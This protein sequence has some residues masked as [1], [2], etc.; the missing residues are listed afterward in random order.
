MDDENFKLAFVYSPKA[1]VKQSKIEIGKSFLL[2]R[3]SFFILIYLSNY[4]IW[5]TENRF[6][7]AANDILTHRRLL[8]PQY[9]KFSD[10]RILL[11]KSVKLFT[12]RP[13]IMARFPNLL[14]NNDE[15][16]K[17]RKDKLNK[18]LGIVT[19]TI[20]Y[21]NGLFTEEVFTMVLDF[22]YTGYLNFPLLSLEHILLVYE[23][24]KLLQYSILEITLLSFLTNNMGLHNAFIIL[25]FSHDHQLAELKKLTLNFCFNNWQTISASKDGL[26]IIG[27]ALFQEITILKGMGETPELIP[28]VAMPNNSIVEDFCNVRSTMEYTD[29]VAMFGSITIPF[30]SFILAASSFKLAHIIFKDYSTRKVPH[31]Y[32]ETISPEAFSGFLDLAYCGCTSMDVIYA[33]ELLENFVV[34]FEL[35]EVRDQCEA[36]LNTPNVINLDNIYRLSS[37][38][39]SPVQEDR[40]RLT[41][42]LKLSCLSF[43]CTFFK[44][45]SP[46][47][48]EEISPFMTRDVLEILHSRFNLHNVSGLPPL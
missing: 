42:D 32:F 23:A 30:H 22:I 18:H 38:C 9:V 33:C 5:R 21:R 13:I 48:I 45:I 20:R 41:N 6:Q 19:T 27:L 3:V 12:F 26:S 35:P 46:Q 17:R 37:V 36:L 8:N 10:I 11:S 25:K 43:I 15:I 7:P 34:P 28:P 2:F 24:A 1:K 47:K 31:F 40:K 4:T 16:I 44:S 29:A 14:A 39:Y